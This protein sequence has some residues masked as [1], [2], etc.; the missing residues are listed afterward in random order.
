MLLGVLFLGATKAFLRL[1]GAGC[2]ASSQGQR[3]LLI[4]H[5]MIHSSL[6][7]LKIRVGVSQLS[8]LINK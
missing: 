3:S 7:E 5:Y 2:N 1:I 6:H 4:K 8:Q